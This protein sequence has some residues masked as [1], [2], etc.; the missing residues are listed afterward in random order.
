RRSACYSARASEAETGN[1]GEQL[2]RG[3]AGRSKAPQALTVDHQV[4]EK[5]LLR[6]GK[7]YLLISGVVVE[8]RADNVGEVVVA[9]AVG[10]DGPEHRADH[11]WVAGGL[12]QPV[13]GSG[14][15]LAGNDI[16]HRLT[17][18]GGYGVSGEEAN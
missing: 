10:V 18:N 7:G 11:A 1:A 15:S 17:D 6:T 13:P 4:A 12:A 9:A 16:V 8:L 2:D 14:G 3:M 5:L